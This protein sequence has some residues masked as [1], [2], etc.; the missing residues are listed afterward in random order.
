MRAD[1]PDR[2]AGGVGA[3]YGAVMDTP[4]LRQVETW[5][6]AEHNAAAWMRH[7]GFPDANA[8][9]GGPDHGVDVHATGAIAQVKFQGAAVGRPALQRLVGAQE[10][11]GDQLFFFTA[12]SYSTAAVTYADERDIALFRYDPWGRMTP[13]NRRA[14]TVAAV[15]AHPDPLAAGGVTALRVSLAAEHLKRHWAAWAGGY[16]LLAAPALAVDPGSHEPGQP[17]A[18]PWWLD[19]AVWAAIWAVGAA[20]LAHYHR[21]RSARRGDGHDT[22]SR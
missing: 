14:A 1:R 5:Q 2:L 3:V 10:G 21:T 12:S 16:L 22:R 19:A 6:D 13:Q 17:F 18:G 4:P 7:W 20:L 8:R 9:P 15:P 11:P